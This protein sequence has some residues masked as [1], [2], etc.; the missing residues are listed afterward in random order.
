MPEVHNSF[1]TK[2]K[3]SAAHKFSTNFILYLFF[4]DVFSLFCFFL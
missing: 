2:K 1:E 4:K 3:K